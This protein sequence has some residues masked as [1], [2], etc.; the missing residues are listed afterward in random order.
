MKKARLQPVWGILILRPDTDSAA[1]HRTQ[2]ETQI[3]NRV[4]ESEQVL[5]T[6]EAAVRGVPGHPGGSEASG[7]KGL[8]WSASSC[9]KNGDGL[10]L[11]ASK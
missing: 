10:V 1:L 6:F 9:V 2:P 3:G 5:W 7:G 4:F 8:Y 11:L